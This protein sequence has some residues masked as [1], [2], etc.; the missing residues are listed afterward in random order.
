MAVEPTWLLSLAIEPTWLLSL[1]PGA[2][3]M[4]VAPWLLSLMARLAF[5]R[6]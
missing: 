4:V 1:E 3:C 6:F 2:T 5:G